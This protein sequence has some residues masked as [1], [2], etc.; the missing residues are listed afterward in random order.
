[1]IKYSDNSN[2][3]MEIFCFSSP[4]EV[5]SRSRQQGPPGEAHITATARKQDKCVLPLGPGSSAQGMG[6]SELR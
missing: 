6:L 1:M 5:L 2:L 4:F 3:R